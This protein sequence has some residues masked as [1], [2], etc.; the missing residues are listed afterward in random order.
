MS[1]VHI[2]IPGNHDHVHIQSAIMDSTEHRRHSDILYVGVLCVNQCPAGLRLC[3]DI[4]DITYALSRD[5]VDVKY[6]DIRPVSYDMINR[7]GA[8]LE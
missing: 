3:G 1:D 6:R 4:P 8:G 7:W 5:H 2:R